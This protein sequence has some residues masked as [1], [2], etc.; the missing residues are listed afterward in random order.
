MDEEFIMTLSG[1]L[2]ELMV[3]TAPNIYQKYVTLDSNNRP[4]MYVFLQKA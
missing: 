3:Q 2:A 1:R 4:V